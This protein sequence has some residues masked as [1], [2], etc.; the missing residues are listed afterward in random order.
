ARRRRVPGQ[1]P[2]PIDAVSSRI[3]LR[4][5]GMPGGRP[6]LA[7]VAGV[8][9][10]DRRGQP[11][12]RTARKVEIDR[13]AIRRGVRADCQKAEDAVLLAAVKAA[14]S[15]ALDLAEGDP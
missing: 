14:V 13:A 9:A 2:K 8:A 4:M 15:H 5:I 1:I 11:D 7:E 6:G 12:R 10:N 3:V